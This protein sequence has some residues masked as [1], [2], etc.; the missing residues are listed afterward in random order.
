VGRQAFLSGRRAP[1]SSQKSTASRLSSPIISGATT[2]ANCRPTWSPTSVRAVGVHLADDAG[3]GYDAPEYDR[4]VPVRLLEREEELSA[5]L[6]AVREASGGDGRFVLLAG[7]AGAGKTSLL[8]QLRNRVNVVVAACE[9]LSVPAPL[10]PIRELAPDLPELEGEDR[11]ALA[12]A[13]LEVVTDRAD[14]V[15]VVEDAH[16]ADP[17]TLDVLRALARRIDA[18]P[19]TVMVSYRDDESRANP[20]LTAFLGDLASIRAVRRIALRPLSVEA[21]ATMAEPVGADAAELF[22]LT[23]GN[24]FLVVEAVGAADGLPTTVQE[25]TLARLA[26][27]DGAAR[28][29]VEAAAIVGPRVPLGLLHEIEPHETA[30]LEALLDRGVLIEEGLELEFRHELTRQAIE[31]SISA[32]RAAELHARALAA[33]ADREPARLAHHAERA[34][35][36]DEAARYAEQAAT[37][38][39]RIGALSEASRQLERALQAPAA[40]AERFEL[41]LRFAR[42]TNFAG[43]LEHACSAAEEAVDLA[44]RELDDAAAG[45]ALIVLSWSLWSLDSVEDARSAADRAVAALAASGEAEYARALAARLRM[46]SIAFD[47]A[48]VV[49][50]A[51]SALRLAERLRS[52]DARVDIAISLGLAQGHLGDRGALDTLLTALG[53][54]QSAR[55]PFQTIRAYVNAVDVAAEIRAH[56]TVDRLAAEAIQQLDTFQTAIPLQTV[57][58]SLARSLLDRGRFEE[59]VVLARASR[60]DA[61]GGVPLALGLEGVV[62]ARRGEGGDDLLDRAWSSL[63]GVPDGWRHGVIRSWRAEAAWLRGEPDAIPTGGTGSARQDA[64][65]QTWTARAH[66]VLAGDWRADVAHWQALEAP[67]EAALAALPGDEAAAG[68]ALATLRRLGAH[69]T[70]RAFIRERRRLGFSAPRGP[71]ASTLANPAGLTRR[72]HEV[73]AHVARGA[74]NPEI[75]SAL[76][77]SER[78]VAHH[79]SAILAKLEAPTR[80]AA[81]EAARKLGLLQDGTASGLT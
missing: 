66:G 31:E 50:E 29:V 63:T 42:A 79:L 18:L 65:L 45:R 9:P 60:R 21:V 12:R 4:S 53:D 32:P 7:E 55:L 64:E 39:E 26:R 57:Q 2:D 62:L 49:A 16:W 34:G 59:A 17:A 75:A 81:V 25:A 1:S 28:A 19:V 30:A 70:A 24:P 10:A 67:Y 8:R 78:T 37:Q 68:K 47:P 15:F 76:H 20:A 13:L 35:L 69:G 27:L 51:P 14:T 22:R 48:I 56:A 77:L 54:A 71:R 41:L 40:P 3:E 52:E 23:K 80:T 61:H 74:T 73:L 11:V 43:G 44:E 5:L 58:L 36:R 72:Q 38:A 33:L 6:E 46:E